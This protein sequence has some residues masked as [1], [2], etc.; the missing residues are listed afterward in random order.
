MIASRQRELE[1]KA[2]LERKVDLRVK[3]DRER[4]ELSKQL[5]FNRQKVLDA[6]DGLVL[7][8]SKELTE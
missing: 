3:V 1:E 8:K 6:H 2:L 4:Q 5:E 7:A